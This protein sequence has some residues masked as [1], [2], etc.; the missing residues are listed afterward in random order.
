GEGAGA[1]DEIKRIGATLTDVLRDARRG[2]LIREG[3]TVV[4]VGRP[5][6][7]KSSLFNRLAGAERAIVTDVAGTTRDLVTEL[8]D[9]DGIAVTLVDTAGLRQAPG[10]VVE[11]EGIARAR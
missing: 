1:H 2:R 7:G 6:S 11:T 3:A 10:D 9:I 5:N 4:L 8:V